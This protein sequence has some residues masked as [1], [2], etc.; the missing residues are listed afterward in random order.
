[1]LKVRGLVYDKWL[2]DTSAALRCK[3][4]YS[5]P[6]VVAGHRLG[7]AVRVSEDSILG[8]ALA[9]ARANP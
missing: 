5:V 7:F 6:S 8:C 4:K 9:E 2:I 3:A 1:M